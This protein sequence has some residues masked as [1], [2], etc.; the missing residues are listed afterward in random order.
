MKLRPSLARWSC[1][2]FTLAGTAWLGQELRFGRS[3]GDSVSKRFRT[4]V[5]LEMDSIDLVL[6]GQPADP[7]MLGIPTDLGISAGYLLELVDE[8]VSVADGRATEF[9]RTFDGFESWSVDPEGSEQSETHSDVVDRELRYLWDQEEGEYVPS[10]ADGESGDEEEL[11]TLASDLDLWSLLPEGEVEEGD[12]WSLDGD[13]VAHVLIPGLDVR[14]AIQ[15]DADVPEAVLEAVVAFLD[16]LSATATLEG[17]EEVDGRSCAVITLATDVSES[18]ELDP[19]LFGPDMAEAGI[20]DFEA[21]LEIDLEIEGRCLW[22]VERGGFRAFE[23]EGVGSVTFDV[24]VNI[25]E[26]GMD[27]EAVVELSLLVEQRTEAEDLE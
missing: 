9:L 8:Y 11:A 4:E 25:V 21:S 27:L 16:D 7:A 19:Q 18:L 12:R 22:D 20:E 15:G 24:A 1:L 5:S 13:A 14:S 2:A 10:F 17:E 6:N 3:E 26:A 23:L